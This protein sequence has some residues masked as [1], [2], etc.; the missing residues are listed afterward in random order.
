MITFYKDMD[1]MS[2]TVTEAFIDTPAGAYYQHKDTKKIYQI[3]TLPIKI[4]H[5]EP[6]VR[7]LVCTDNPH[8]TIFTTDK[9]LWKQTDKQG[10][11]VKS[12]Q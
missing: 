10:N 7:Y 3:R 8:D 9:R 11:L 6:R 2:K 5:T 1:S 4:K 12:R